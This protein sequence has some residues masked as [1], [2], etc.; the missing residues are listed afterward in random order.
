MINKWNSIFESEIFCFVSSHLNLLVMK[1][2]QIIP[3]TKLKKNYNFLMCVFLFV[4]LN[5]IKWVL[6]VTISIC[7]F[8]MKMLLVIGAIYIN[9][10][11]PKKKCFW[12][13]ANFTFFCFLQ[14]WYCRKTKTHSMFC[15]GKFNILVWQV[16]RFI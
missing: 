2:K 14:I 12:Y 9:V 5:F 1:F 15:F 10:S 4:C 6:L 11:Q 16:N 3:W 8:C 7:R 13:M